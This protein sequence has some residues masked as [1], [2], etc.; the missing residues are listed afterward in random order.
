MEKWI[1]RRRACTSPELEQRLYPSLQLS[2]VSSLLLPLDHFFWEVALWPE[3]QRSGSFLLKEAQGSAC[4]CFSLFQC[5]EFNCSSGGI[6][7]DCTTVTVRCQL[8]MPAGLYDH[9]NLPAL[10]EVT[11]KGNLSPHVLMASTP[12]LSA[13]PPFSPQCILALAK[14]L[15]VE[16]FRSFIESILF[17][18]LTSLE[19]YRYHCK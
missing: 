7:V 11:S 10:H 14:G 18:Q 2:F 9:S 6:K 12:S 13:L 19:Y 17:I 1:F 4:G 15:A 3:V 5:R 16:N 8:L